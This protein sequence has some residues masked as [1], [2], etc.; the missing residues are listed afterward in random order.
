MT[1][2]ST[3]LF[4]QGTSRVNG[5][6]G[7]VFGDGLRCVAGTVRRLG[8]TTNVNGSSEF[9][10]VGAA[11]SIAGQIP[12]GGA[13]TRYYQAWYRDA[14]VSFCSPS[15]FNLTNGLEVVWLP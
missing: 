3:V 2:T 8:T 14:S 15:R 13:V 1:S 4:F 6:A 7:S 9:P 12:S 5:G 11:I 10:G